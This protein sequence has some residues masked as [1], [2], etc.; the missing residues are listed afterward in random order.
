FHDA[1]L[2]Q[3][4]P[5]VPAA[6]GESRQHQQEEQRD[7]EAPGATA[8]LAGRRFGSVF[9]PGRGGRHDRNVVVFILG[10]HREPCRRECHQPARAS[11][12]ASSEAVAATT[13]GGRMSNSCANLSIRAV[14]T[15]S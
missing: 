13:G 6:C 14:G 1:L 5:A 2:L 11:S 9:L 15:T 3:P 4:L 8:R 7:E 12:N 10:S